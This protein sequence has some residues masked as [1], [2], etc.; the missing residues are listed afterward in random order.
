MKK[1]KFSLDDYIERGQFYLLNHKF[2]EAIKHFQKALEIKADP[3]LYYQLGLAYEGAN[4]TSEAR[5]M[6]RKALE[7][8]PALKEAEERLKNISS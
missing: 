3:L 6:Y 7:L 4:K 2:C 5:E 1:T 8:N